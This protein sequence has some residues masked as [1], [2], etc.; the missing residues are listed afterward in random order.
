M[1]LGGRVIVKIFTSKP[2]PQQYFGIAEGVNDKGDMNDHREWRVP[3]AE[4]NK[5][6]AQNLEDVQIIK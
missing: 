5:F 2:I 3:K 6:L 4:F 1:C